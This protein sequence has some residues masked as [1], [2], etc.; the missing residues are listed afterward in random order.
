MQQRAQHI[1]STVFGYSEFRGDQQ[2][3]IDT[4]VQGRDALVIMPT[5][6]GK[7]LCY[8]V[9]ALLRD[10]LGVVV[11]PL[12]ALMVDQ[13]EGL[14]QSGVNAAALHS[15]QSFA[16]QQAIRLSIELGELDIL[17]VS[18]ERLALSSFV[19]WLQNQKIALIAIDE[20]H[21][22][23]E[24]GHDFRADYLTLGQLKHLFPQ[25]PRI[26]LTA[27]ADDLTQQDIVSRL[28]L[29]DAQFFLGGFDRPNIQYRIE[30]KYKEKDQLLAFIKKEYP[31]ESGIVYC[32]SR[33]KTEQM[34]EFLREQGINALPYHAGMDSKLREINQHKFLRDDAV[35]M[36]ATIAFG[37]GIDKP[38]VRY[39]VHLNL[40]KSIEAYSQET[41]RAG[42]D[43][44]PSTALLL[45]GNQDIV[46]TMKFIENTDASFE[47]KQLNRYKLERLI[48]I[49]ELTSC[50][51]QG[52][53]HYFGQPLAEP[54]QNC[55]TCLQPPK[56]YNA[57]Q[58]VQKALSAIYRVGQN[59]PTGYL[60]QLLLGKTSERIEA[61]EH[62]KLSVFGIGKEL[63][64]T[65]W[66]SV[67]R[68]II[69]AHWVDVD[70][71]T[72]RLRLNERCRSILKGESQV[73]L[74]E[75]EKADRKRQA[76]Q[77]SFD[78]D[79]DRELWQ[80]LRTV[81]RD[82][83]KSLDIPPYQVFSDATL[84]EFV[85]HKPQNHREFAAI[86]GVGKYKLD[87][88][89]DDFLDAILIFA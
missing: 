75:D 59:A 21:C 12:I 54:C 71:Q 10:G 24:W 1:L 16:E 79:E 76:N 43:G 27:T 56:T 15:G 83:A 47:Q 30:P 41:G 58:V 17:Y 36:V 82:L 68:Q 77:I 44:M 84:A 57:T 14:R 6:G 33:N 67:F 9:P 34:A 89:A 80:E 39:V 18:P 70:P 8:Q 37:M 42:R 32:M 55:D 2:A 69:A 20:A 23:S 81:R 28:E 72:Q 48:G 26:A 60:I 61:A 73:F 31:N 25:V 29:T 11:S 86:S 7:S 62:H 52:L 50:R 46:Q 53:L 5:G 13:V 49:C 3:I 51:R 74:R 66:K 78:S 35:V 64:D 38:D 45:Y 65:Q 85:R 4:L 22:I 40:P 87:K 63:S 19:A 88:F